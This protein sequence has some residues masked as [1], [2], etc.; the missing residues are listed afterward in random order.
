MLLAIAVP[1]LA[2]TEE[3]PEEFPEGHEQGSHVHG[4]KLYNLISN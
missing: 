3:L 1:I 2:R 4:K